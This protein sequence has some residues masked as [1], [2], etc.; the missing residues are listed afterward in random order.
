MIPAFELGTRFE[1]DADLCEL[2]NIAADVIPATVTLRRPD[3]EY[4]DASLL[5]AIA[6]FRRF[7]AVDLP[8]ERDAG[9]IVEDLPKWAAEI[10]HERARHVREI[11]TGD[12][13]GLLSET[14]DPRFSPIQTSL[15]DR[16]AM[17]VD[18]LREVEGYSRSQ[19][20]R[21]IRNYSGDGSGDGGGVRG[22]APYQP[23]A[24]REGDPRVGLD[25][26]TL[27]VVYR[28]LLDMRQHGSTTHMQ[29][30]VNR[31]AK[32][33]EEAHIADPMLTPTR[34]E[35]LLR[36]LSAEWQLSSKATTRR[37]T[38]ARAGRGR[39]RPPP[40]MPGERVE[41]DSTWA[42]VNVVCPETGKVFRP[43]LS[44]AICVATRLIVIR[45]TPQKPTARDSRLLI[46][47]LMRPLVLP[48]EL[49]APILPLGKPSQVRFSRAMNLGIVVTDHGTEYEN[50]RMVDCLAR[51]GTGVEL[52]RT[53]RGMDKPY[54][55]SA[56]R[57]LDILEQDLLGYVGSCSDNRGS[58]V[59]AVLTLRALQTICS[60]WAATVYPH[61]PHTG[62][63]SETRPGHFFT[64]AQRY[65]QC[66]IRGG[67]IAVDVH[68][69]DVFGFLDTM[70]LTIA[71]D[72]VHYKNFRYSG[73]VLSHIEAGR[74]SPLAR[75]G[76]RRR[77]YFDPYDRSRLFFR[78]DHEQRWHTLHAVNE[79]DEAYP[80]FS[81]LI[82]SDFSRFLARGKLTR[83][84]RTNADV[85][86]MRFAESVAEKDLS[87]WAFD[88]A[89]VE[90]AVP[91]PVGTAGTTE[92][93]GVDLPAQFPIDTDRFA[94][95][96]DRE[97]SAGALW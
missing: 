36:V 34:L 48:D 6:A 65:E 17:K 76:R 30:R 45:V 61:R 75:L 66:L 69:D 78:D 57:T 93:A 44:V 39:R 13:T 68:P 80:P 82:S 50:H 56:N 70:E 95:A 35:K 81:E 37:N 1:Y 90:G 59:P 8:R 63:P 58:D 71:S 4:L 31:V 55:E 5:D 19:L 47:D 92:P 53:G 7:I 23:P 97:D 15:A 12:P 42:N 94:I 49:R 40:V 87:R 3:G 89:R 26:S 62:L 22:L 77:F 74:I 60:E 18:D 64:P 73:D 38:A 54:V 28:V 43:W 67:N 72:G 83:S 14:S 24:A 91:A 16:V 86:F 2:V 20:Y 41:M 85:A 46:F 51:W 29:A 11:L 79:S 10:A 84:E 27:D 9:D 96:D 88:R 32:A 21:M 25:E 33:L 52:A